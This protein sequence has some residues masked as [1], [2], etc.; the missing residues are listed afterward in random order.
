VGPGNSEVQPQADFVYQ[1]AHGR[2]YFTH[3]V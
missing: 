2:R 1:L 3:A